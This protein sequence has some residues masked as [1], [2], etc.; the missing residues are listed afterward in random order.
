[1]VGEDTRLEAVP[2]V[3]PARKERRTRRTAC[4]LD[5]EV[6]QLHPAVRLGC[7][8]TLNVP[9]AQEAGS[10]WQAWGKSPCASGAYSTAGTRTYGTA[11]HVN[12]AVRQPVDVWRADLAAGVAE[13]SVAE[14]V[15]HDEDE[16]PRFC[17]RRRREG[18]CDRRQRDERLQGRGGWHGVQRARAGSGGPAEGRRLFVGSPPPPPPYERGGGAGEP[19]V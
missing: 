11:V 18:F 12:T 6:A 19:S 7:H 8:G 16:V 2:D 5:V 15:R 13:V 3:V 9:E 10:A 1:V 17:L 14:I 4:P